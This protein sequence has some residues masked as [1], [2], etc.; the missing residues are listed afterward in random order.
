MDAAYFSAMAAL[1]GSAI[2]AISSIMTTWL[3]QRYQLEGQRRSGDHS[4]LERLSVEFI[5]HASV[6]LVDALQ[7]TALRDPAKLAPLYATLGKLR[8]FAPDDML[9]HAEDAMKSI[10]DLYY[11]PPIDFEAKPENADDIDLLRSFEAA[12]RRTLRGA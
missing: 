8:L 3:T 1:F 7:Q 6:L 10:I 11:G 9:T 4:R 2:G 5:E 12:C